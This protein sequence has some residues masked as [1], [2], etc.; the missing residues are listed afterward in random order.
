MHC[1][2]PHSAHVLIA[3]T[4]QWDALQV[5]IVENWFVRIVVIV[6]KTYRI[7]ADL[8]RVEEEV[9][10]VDQISLERLGLRLLVALRDVGQGLPEAD[11]GLDAGHGPHAGVGAAPPQRVLAASLLSWEFWIL[12]WD[13]LE[14]CDDISSFKI[15][16]II[17]LTWTK[18]ISSNVFSIRTVAASRMA[19]QTFPGLVH[20]LLPKH[21]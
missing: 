18:C 12:S 2:V 9:D 3:I 16:L 6:V 20:K 13:I 7:L 11:D 14:S 10:L 15:I 1:I 8:Q 4:I 5:Q 21:D 17:L 19:L